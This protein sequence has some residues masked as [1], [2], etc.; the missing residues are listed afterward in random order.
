[1][2][3]RT[4]RAADEGDFIPHL[5]L[6]LGIW[7]AIGCVGMLVYFVGHMAGRINVETVVVLVS[8]DMQA[9]LQR[10]TQEEPGEA[11]PPAAYWTLAQPVRDNRQGYLQHLDE[12]GLADWAADRQVAI[13]LLVRPGDYVFPGAPIA[14][15]VPQV[16]GVE[17]AIRDATGASP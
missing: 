10:L 8:E 15:V 1:M 14:Q 12:A 13:R 4:V 3:R 6:S 5:A 17:D 11:P 16:D 2:V 9:A 7:L